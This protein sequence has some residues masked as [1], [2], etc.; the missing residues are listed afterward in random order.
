MSLLHEILINPRPGEDPADDRS[1]NQSGDQPEVAPVREPFRP[2]ASSRASVHNDQIHALVQQLFFSDESKTV[3]HVGFAPIEGS[4]ATATLCLDV[5]RAVS[6]RHKYDVG[7]IDA[8]A[9]SGSLHNQLHIEP[10][11]RAEV[12]WSIA[13]QLWLAP[14]R[15]WLRDPDGQRVTEQDL[16]RLRELTLEFDF[17]ILWCDPVSW[18]TTSIARTCDGLVLVLAANKTRRIVAAQVRD[19]LRRAQIPLLGTVLAERRFPVPQGL[20][21]S[22]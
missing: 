15:N 3:R 6:E 19:Q 2:A 14:R 5:A 21:R 1:G 7:V 20:Y 8:R 16:A 13:P 9:E 11:N 4:T 10:P 12:T 17:S 22:L 18:L